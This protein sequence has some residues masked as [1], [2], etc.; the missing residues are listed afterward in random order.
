[1][2]LNIS[3]CRKIHYSVWLQSI[4]TFSIQRLGIFDLQTYNLVSIYPDPNFWFLGDAR[5][6]FIV[7]LKGHWLWVCIRSCLHMTLKRVFR[8][9]TYTYMRLIFLFR[10]QCGQRFICLKFQSISTTRKSI[11]MYRFSL[12]SSRNRKRNIFFEFWKRLTFLP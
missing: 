3:N 9:C 4:T 8:L 5:R 11:N 12:R 1:M 2:A 7:S 6:E 10:I